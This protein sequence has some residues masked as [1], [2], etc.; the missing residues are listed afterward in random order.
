MRAAL[1]AAAKA[2]PAYGAPPGWS[3][4]VNMRAWGPR[5]SVAWLI[6]RQE[7]RPR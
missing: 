4:A 6:P 5:S 7:T 1:D 3:P 2:G